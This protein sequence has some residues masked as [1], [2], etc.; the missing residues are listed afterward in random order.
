[1][2]TL[3][4]LRNRGT[5][6]DRLSVTTGSDV[7]C[8]IDVLRNGGDLRAELLLDTVEVEAIFVRY[9]VDGESQMTKPTRSANAVKVGFRVLGEIKV[10]D[11]VDSLNI[12]TTSKEVGAH[13]VSTHPVAEVMED[14]VTVRLQHFR[15]RVETGI[16]K[17]GDLL[18]KQFD[19]VCR[20]AEND[21]LV[22]LQLTTRCQRRVINVFTA[23]VLTL[24][25]RVLRQWT[26]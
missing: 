14:A 2:L 17:F 20:V 19:P 6:R 23:T 12:D 1:M 21:R 9:Q 8:T 11:D 5:L 25:K 3:T 16:S 15:V 13:E 18:C 4:F 10:D 24:E 26:F 22:D 7:E